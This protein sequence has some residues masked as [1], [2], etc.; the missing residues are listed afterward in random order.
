MKKIMPYIAS[1]FLLLGGTIASQAEQVKQ[2]SEQTVSRRIS[3]NR[4]YGFLTE[5]NQHI[6]A[7]L[8]YFGHL[9]AGITRNLIKAKIFVEAGSPADRKGAFSHD[10]MQIANSGDSA[11]EGLVNSDENLDLIGDFSFL[12]GISATPRKDGKW[13]YSNSQM[14]PEKSIYGGIG[15]LIH[16]MADVRFRTVEEGDVLTYTIQSGDS[17]SKIAPQL[18]TTTN[19]LRKY[20]QVDPKKLR[21]GQVVSYRK[22]RTE[23]YIHGWES[24]E[25]GIRRYNGGGDP[26]YLAKVLKAKADLDEMDR[27]NALLFANK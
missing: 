21:E 4:Q 7:A 9:G 11:L 26:N 12:K 22:A 2:S 10:P 14:T 5:H 17:F 1:A 19:V 16:Y 25:H 20:N 6:D 13:D 24:A 3:L 8:A 27:L 15:W 18:G 23:R